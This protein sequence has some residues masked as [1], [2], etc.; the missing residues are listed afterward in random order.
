[1]Q[2]VHIVGSDLERL[3]QIAA[4]FRG[5]GWTTSVSTKTIALWEMLR[6]WVGRQPY[7]P[8]AVIVVA[9]GDA[10]LDPEGLFE[11]ATKLRQPFVCEPHIAVGVLTSAIRECILIGSDVVEE[12]DT[13]PEKMLRPMRAALED[14]ERRRDRLRAYEAQPPYE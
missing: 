11:V 9:E 5:D 10:D 1:M 4:T 12:F 13:P 8:L 2:H 6:E 3:E 14:R 7:E